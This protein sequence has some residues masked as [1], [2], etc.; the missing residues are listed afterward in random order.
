MIQPSVTLLGILSFVIGAA[1][2][3]NVPAKYAIQP[4]SNGRFLVDADGDPFFWQADTAWL[5]FHRLNYTEAGEYLSDRANKGFT[6]ALAVG[7][8]QEGI[9]SPNR[10]GDL[11]FI[12]LDP[13]KPNEAYW[14]YVDSIIELAWSKGI[15]ICMVPAWGSQIH[16]STN[17]AGPINTT[18][19]SAFG[20]FIGQRYPYLPKTLV[21]DT[22]PWWENKTA[23]KT[24]YTSGGVPSDYKVV[25]WSNVYDDLATGIV[26]GERKTIAATTSVQKAKTW[27][28]L[29]TIHPTNQWFT[30]GPVA[31]ASAFFGDRQWLTLDT[32]QSG[33]A[34][35]PPNPPIPWW[36]CRRGWEPIELMY[37]AGSKAGS[38]TRPVIDNEAHYENRYDNGNSIYPY[39]N[40]SDVRTGSWQAVF[41]GASGLTYGANAIQQMAIPGIY[42]SDG[43]GPNDDWLV[44]LVAPGSSQMQ[45]IKK[46][47]MD[48]GSSTFFKRLPAQDII[49][50][51]AGDNDL[52]ITATRDGSGTWVMVYTPTGLPFKINTS[53]LSSCKVQA[54]WFD[55]VAGNYSA[56]DYSQCGSSGMSRTFSPPLV[57][58]HS[59]WVLVL[60]NLA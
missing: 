36:N 18:T 19:A 46:A 52:R 9:S 45:W 16:D 4:S 8:T 35:F 27:R 24:D 49:M 55:P 3:W 42:S 37:A 6:V 51:D 10:N 58:E 7:F 43:T 20:K 30:G 44:D 11:T 2:A 23:V 56:F 22:N 26:A 50:S 1:A 32:S 17:N 12:D 60:E 41:S 48:R 39:W 57:D 14:S 13:T 38:R 15:R 47:I 59:D 5:L 28:P 25:D 53:S 21:A 33:H 31:V 40:A 54:Q 34:D 29:M